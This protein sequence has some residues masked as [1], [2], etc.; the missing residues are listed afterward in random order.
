[1]RPTAERRK[2][3]FRIIRRMKKI[4]SYYNVRAFKYDGQY[5]NGM[6]W[7]SRPDSASKTTYKPSDQRKIDSMDCKYFEYVTG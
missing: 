2:N 7:R 6:P 1:M 3:G 4:S 5:S